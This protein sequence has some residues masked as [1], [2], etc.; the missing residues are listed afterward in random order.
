MNAAEVLGNTLS[1][2]ATVRAAAEKALEDASRDNFPTY[3]AMLASEMANDGTELPLR[4]AAALAVKNAVTARDGA[5][6]EEYAQRWL[7]LP[8]ESRNDVKAK[9]LGTL[10]TANEG[11]GRNAAQV[12]ASI[13]A[14][15]LPAGSWQELISQLLA[16]IKDQGNE[17]LRQSAL[18]AIGYVCET[19]VSGVLSAQSN[20]ILTAVVHGAR[21]EEPSTAVQLAAIQALLNSLEFVSDNFEREGERNYIM[22]VVCEATQSPDVNVKVSSYECLVRIMQ[23]YY[24]MMRYYMEQA[25]FGLTV[26]GMRDPE[27]RV[28]LQAVE[29]WSTVCEEEID[30]A[31]EAAEFSEYGE[32]SERSCYN[33]A[34]IALS[35]IAPVLMELLKAQDENDDED[36][37]NVAKAAGTCIGLLANC[38]QDDIVPL[39]IPFID[40]N[41]RSPD[42]QSRDAAVLCF[43]SVLDGPDSVML[44]PLVEQALPTVIEMLQDSS[45]AVKDSAAWTLG[46]ITDLLAKT[47]SPQNHLTPLVQA[48][49]TSLQDEPRISC[50]CSWALTRL[51]S[52]FG[53]SSPLSEASMDGAGAAKAEDGFLQTSPIS[54]FYEGITSALLQVASRPTNENNSRSA[55]FE[56][57]SEAVDRAP[58]DCISN[59]SNIILQLLERQE[60]LNSLA[61]QLVGMD[62]KNNWVEMQSSISGVVSAAL[63]RL[64]KEILPLGDRIM[65]NLLTL[66]QH[67]SKIPTVLEDAFL[68][69]GSVVQSF[70]ADFEKY[71]EA[72]L[73]FLV[74][75]IGNHEATQLC[76]VAVGVVGDLCNGLGAGMAKYSQQLMTALF[77][78]LQSSVI[79]RDVKPT[80]L[81]CFGDMAL[82]I[83]ADFEP[84]LG[85]TMVVLQQAGATVSPPNDFA[86]IDYVNYLRE[87]VAEALTGIV[88]GL[89]AAGRVDLLQ[90]HVE[91]IVGFLTF[92]ATHTFDRTE[93]LL[94][95]ALGLLGDLASTFA[96]GQ[97][98]A[99]LTQPAIAELIKAG[100]NR[101]LE[102]D[103]RKLAAYARDEVKKATA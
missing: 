66:I 79:H 64:G 91:L 4:T 3:V 35:E 44:T 15:E 16:A 101:T 31:M 93:S 14:I 38:V 56:A 82:A 100:R 17:R 75:A 92:V 50:N 6:Q 84:F 37:W 34:R 42:W 85:T 83:G 94:K 12:V 61:D 24:H 67:G 28:A 1:P 69:V 19:T 70:D 32:E 97:L 88:A 77:E 2:D 53:G 8:E 73:P 65:T 103:T 78:G 46:R 98:K 21:K 13:A 45:V 20:E 89:N 102:T 57:I 54:P 48:L 29:F 62:D 43:G 7:A 23:L 52:E 41:I 36:D 71:L 39:A 11:I 30:I 60:R 27:Q 10:G 63:R 87:A 86:M 33:F 95:A 18:Q 76:S 58:R 99:A 5:R 22:Q 81:R 59:V 40:Q 51:V 96:N 55:A 9:A 72:F 47:I 74:A 25:L 49:V 80:I 68:A 26:L 90:P